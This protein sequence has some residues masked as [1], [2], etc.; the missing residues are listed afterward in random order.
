MIMDELNKFNKSSP[1]F[2]EDV[3]NSNLPE[4]EQYLSKL[5]N[6]QDLVQNIINNFDLFSSKSLKFRDFRAK[7]LYFLSNNNSNDKFQTPGEIIQEVPENL[8]NMLSISQKNSEIKEN[9]SAILKATNLDIANQKNK[10]KSNSNI[11]IKAEN[12]LLDSKRINQIEESPKILNSAGSIKEIL[13]ESNQFLKEA[14]EHFEEP[15]SL[16]E[17]KK[18]NLSPERDK[19]SIKSA[20][21]SIKKKELFV[22]L[23]E[24]YKK[25]SVSNKRD[26]ERED[27]VN[28]IESMK[29]DFEE[30]LL[31]LQTEIRNL[32]EDNIRKKAEIKGF[33][34]CLLQKK[35]INFS[36]FFYSYVYLLFN[37]CIFS[38]LFINL[39]V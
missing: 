32:R 33:F 35:F 18:V 5:L 16:S 13:N 24:K 22:D 29:K 30:R 2:M 1:K 19:E 11:E 8:E 12:K 10:L 21:G 39:Y 31:E 27:N 34:L 28:F 36:H 4:Q 25:S 9:N 14:Q 23:S 26:K 15:I 38:F 3:I 20:Q 37:Y 7:C 6:E 17:F